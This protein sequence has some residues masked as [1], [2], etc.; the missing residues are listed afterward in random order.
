VL[1]LV[2]APASAQIST[3]AV[4]TT[5]AA[6]YLGQ[7]LPAETGPWV[8]GEVLFFS[9]DRLVSDYTWREKVRG[10]RGTLYTKADILG[11]VESLMTLPNF[12][13]IE[14]R[15]YAIPDSPVAPEFVNIAVSSAQV[16]LVFHVTEK[17]VTEAVT[18]PRAAIP[19]AAVSGVVLTPTAWRGAGRYSTPGMGLDINGMYI[20]GRL[21]GKNSFPDAPRKTNYIDR[22]GVWLLSADG[23]MQVQSEGT[24]RPAVAVGGQGTFLFR[25]S[26]QPTVQNQTVTVKVSEKST[27]LFSAG[28]VVASKKIGPVRSSVGVMQGN[29]GDIVAHMSEFLTSEAMRFYAQR[30]N[31]RVRSRTVPF[32]S[33]FGLPK[34]SYPLGFEVMKFNGAPL[35]PW[36]IN[37]KLGYFLKL[38]FD[39]SYLKYQGGYD[40]LGVVQFRYN[41]FP[42]R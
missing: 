2:L 33:M 10:T 21:Y 25:D 17:K 20:I 41:H 29:Q 11:D 38:N 26:P 35:S 7:P 12:E 1:A 14:P 3:S 9:S 23:K 22:L 5:G 42:R 30:P 40:V 34:P 37:F 27:K 13:R 24:V 18:K 28:Y 4:T 8:L 32:L 16:R 31:S 19:P 6:A 36:L 15:L 39:V